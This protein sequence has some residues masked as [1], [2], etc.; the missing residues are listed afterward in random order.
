MIFAEGATS[1]RVRTLIDSFNVRKD[2]A[3]IGRG[4]AARG[5]VAEFT[6][7]KA[8]NKKVV[9]GTRSGEVRN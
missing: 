2:V 3:A 9:E 5:V 6:K 8:V 7:V 4:D 1:E